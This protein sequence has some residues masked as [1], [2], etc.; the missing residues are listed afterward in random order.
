MEDTSRSL[1]N[2]TQKNQKVY[3]LLEIQERYNDNKQYR[4]INF[5]FEGHNF[6]DETL[7]DNAQV[8]GNFTFI[9]SA[10]RRQTDRSLGLKSYRSYKS[11]RVDLSALQLEQLR[12]LLLEMIPTQ[13]KLLNSMINHAENTIFEVG[14]LSVSR[15]AGKE[16]IQGLEND[17][18]GRSNSKV[19]NNGFR[20]SILKTSKGIRT[21]A[22]D[23]L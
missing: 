10:V 4:I 12:Q 22:N 16:K 20:Q 19:A 7:V 13:E 21:A 6:M 17:Y 18:Q 1:A 11:N 3:V 8:V 23:M 9:E 14:Q 15:S 2:K 5:K